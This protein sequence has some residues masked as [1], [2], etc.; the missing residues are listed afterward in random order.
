MFEEQVT[1]FP[2][3]L[4]GIAVPLSACFERGG[5]RNVYD[6]VYRETPSIFPKDNL[7]KHSTVFSKFYDHFHILFSRFH[8]LDGLFSVPYNTKYRTFV[9]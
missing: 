1:D 7:G 3:D 8:C 5:R 4:D 2:A 9:P 6:P